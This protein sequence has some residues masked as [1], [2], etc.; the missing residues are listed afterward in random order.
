MKLIPPISWSS[1]KPWLYIYHK[2]ST[3]D[4]NLCGGSFHSPL[5]NWHWLHAKNVSGQHYDWSSIKPFT[6]IKL[7][8]PIAGNFNLMSFRGLF[9]S[10]T[11]PLS[12][13]LSF[14]LFF[15]IFSQFSKTWVFASG[16]R[17]FLWWSSET[18]YFSESSFLSDRNNIE[19]QPLTE[20]TT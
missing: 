19:N 18:S 6:A 13:W 1:P 5:N 8:L 3:G 14:W 11:S 9:A 12:S 20:T 16:I 7:F 4:W 15:G 2:I 17:I 10:G